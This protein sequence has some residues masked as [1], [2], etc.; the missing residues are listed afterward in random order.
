ML[1]IIASL[2]I[3]FPDLF[4]FAFLATSTTHAAIH[5][6]PAAGVGKPLHLKYRQQGISFDVSYFGILVLNSEHEELSIHCQ[7]I[8]PED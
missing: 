1:D 5:G 7:Q 2:E 3:T 6:V 8:L 4:A